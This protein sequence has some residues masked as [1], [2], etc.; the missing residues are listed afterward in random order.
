VIAL[1][2]REN[3]FAVSIVKHQGDRGHVVIDSGVY[4]VVRHPLYSGVVLVL[5]GVALWLQSYAAAIFS[6]VPIALLFLRIG[7]EEAFLKTRL[8]GYEAYARRVRSRLVP[9]V[10]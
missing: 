3:T 4:S 2:F 8:V 10:W 7:V 5:V 6:I 9:R 1:A